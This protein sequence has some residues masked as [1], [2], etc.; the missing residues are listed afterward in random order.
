[1]LVLLAALIEVLQLRQTLNM[2]R[3]IMRKQAILLS[4]SGK[5]LHDRDC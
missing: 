3:I 2:V 4:A 1:M 5:P